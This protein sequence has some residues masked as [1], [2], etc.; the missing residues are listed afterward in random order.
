MLRKTSQVWGSNDQINRLDNPPF[1]KEKTFEQ[2]QLEFQ[3]LKKK[4]PD[5]LPV[6]LDPIGIEIGKS[7]YLLSPGLKFGVLITNA[8]RYLTNTDAKIPLFFTINGIIIDSETT[9]STLY[10]EYKDDDGFLYVTIYS[11]SGL[12]S[13]THD[14]ISVKSEHI[15]DQ[16]R[17]EE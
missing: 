14:Q 8:R 15:T 10:D 5:L 7:K 9:L 11:E 6:M 13:P 3:R 16:Q 4:H 17:H 12:F 1:K 2:R